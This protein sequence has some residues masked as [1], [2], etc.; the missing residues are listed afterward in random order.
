[1]CRFPIPPFHGDLD[2]LPVVAENGIVLAGCEK[3]KAK[4][5]IRPWIRGAREFV[6]REWLAIDSA[7]RELLDS[8]TLDDD[9]VELAIVRIDE[10][11]SSQE[12]SRQ[13]GQYRA[14]KH[15]AHSRINSASLGQR[16][17]ADGI[18]TAPQARGG[19]LQ[20]FRIYQ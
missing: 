8:R 1:V 10:T 5:R 9:E 11:L 4:D 2:L 3:T 12:Y 16:R 14:F 7:A 18:K 13:L 17:P 19:D 15:F 6:K 20:T